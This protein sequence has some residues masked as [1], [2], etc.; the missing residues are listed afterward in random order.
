MVHLTSNSIGIGHSALI[1]FPGRPDTLLIQPC[2]HFH[3][4]CHH[5]C[6][7]SFLFGFR[8]SPALWQCLLW[9]ARKSNCHP[10]SEWYC[11]FLFVFLPCISRISL[12]D[13]DSTVHSTFPR[14][15][16]KR[17]Q[18]HPSVY[19]SARPVFAPTAQLPD[20]ASA[21]DAASCFFPRDDDPCGSFSEL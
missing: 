15:I 6:T 19:P 5:P 10:K 8:S 7:C 4:I 13:T 3:S 1:R 17:P 18:L 11:S 2:L 20:H 9:D 12:A 14:R 16:S 21:M